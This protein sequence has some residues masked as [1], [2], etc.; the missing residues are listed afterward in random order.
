MLS[1]FLIL[2]TGYGL[3]ASPLFCK[4]MPPQVLQSVGYKGLSPAFCICACLRDGIVDRGRCLAGPLATTTVPRAGG[5]GLD[6]LSRI[7]MISSC[8]LRTFRMP[9]AKLVTEEDQFGDNTPD[10]HLASND[11]ALE[12]WLRTFAIARSSEK[13]KLV[14]VCRLRRRDSSGLLEHGRSH[15]AREYGEVRPF[16]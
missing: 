14:V 3:A 5:I 6:W 9:L 11:K 16:S 4:P 15:P 1:F 7:T 2:V 10:E 12:N 13:P 8:D